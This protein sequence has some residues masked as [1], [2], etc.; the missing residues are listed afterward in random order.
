[1][2]NDRVEAAQRNR[3]RYPNIAAFVDALNTPFTTK[4]IVK[5]GKWEKTVEVHYPRGFDVRVVSIRELSQ[6]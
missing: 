4:N 5:D 6:K 1:M 3:E 2:N